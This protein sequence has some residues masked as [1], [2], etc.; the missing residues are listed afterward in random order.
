[1]ISVV[2]NELLCFKML[3]R[4]V[5][6]FFK[7]N[8]QPAYLCDEHPTAS[9]AGLPSEKDPQLSSRPEM[10]SIEVI[11]RMGHVHEPGTLIIE[12]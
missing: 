4:G 5:N 1:M 11:K 9:F 3:L 6:D 12:N 7:Y 2:E 8:M 10:A